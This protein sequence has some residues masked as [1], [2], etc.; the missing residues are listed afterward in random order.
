MKRPELEDLRDKSILAL[1][2]LFI[3]SLQPEKLQRIHPGQIAAATALHQAC[4]REL[5]DGL[6]GY[7]FDQLM[8]NLCAVEYDLSNAMNDADVE[9]KRVATLNAYTKVCQMVNE[10]WE[11][12]DEDLDDAEEVPT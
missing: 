11:I 2:E 7:N 4:C 6:F 3:G 12:A 5:Q 9:V 1:K 10:F 8:N